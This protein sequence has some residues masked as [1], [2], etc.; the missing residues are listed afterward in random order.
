MAEKRTMLTCFQKYGRKCN[1]SFNDILHVEYRE[2]EDV[3]YLLNI[4]CLPKSPQMAAL[5]ILITRT[6]LHKGGLV[7][8]KTIKKKKIRIGNFF[9]LG[10]PVDKMFYSLIAFTAFYLNFTLQ[11]KHLCKIIKSQMLKQ[12]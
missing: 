2:E 8:L 9:P 11:E 6:C 12:G 5:Q 4:L 10:D 7:S 3:K 1:V